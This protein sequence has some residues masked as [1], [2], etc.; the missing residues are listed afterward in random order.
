[1]QEAEFHLREDLGVETLAL[2]DGVDDLGGGSQAVR[3]LHGEDSQK[4]PEADAGRDLIVAVLAEQGREVPGDDPDIVHFAGKV[5]VLLV[6]A[7]LAVALDA[8]LDLG[9]VAGS[10]QRADPHTVDS[11]GVQVQGGD[12]E[13]CVRDHAGRDLILS[14]GA[15]SCPVTQTVAELGQHQPGNPESAGADHADD[16]A[17][18]RFLALQDPLLRGSEVHGKKSDLLAAYRLVCLPL[19]HRGSPGTPLEN[20]RVF[21]QDVGED[22]VE[23]IHVVEQPHNDRPQMD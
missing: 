9:E 23:D 3:D 20:I 12:K 19:D 6:A 7:D 11:Q 14:V 8:V 21:L 22:R 1:M 16:D 17:A 13:V 2:C 15:K 18:G 5:R 4:L 10:D